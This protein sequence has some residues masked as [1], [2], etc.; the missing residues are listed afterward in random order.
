MSKNI[1]K[2]GYSYLIEMKTL[3]EKEKFLVMF[4]IHQNEHLWSKG[5]KELQESIDMYTGCSNIT[6]TM[7]KTVRGVHPVAMTAIKP[8]KEISQAA[9][10]LS[11]MSTGFHLSAIQVI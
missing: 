8:W 1:D 5:L 2:W 3:W 4:V 10:T 6:E 11:Q 9:S 7:L